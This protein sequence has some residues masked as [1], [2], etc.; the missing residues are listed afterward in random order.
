MISDQVV[1][2]QQFEQSSTSA[3]IPSLRSAQQLRQQPTLQQQELPDQR[4]EGI[5]NDRQFPGNN[6][7]W[8]M[9]G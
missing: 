3:R 5:Q 9:I 2:Q 1:L 6:Q 4:K 8:C 7:V